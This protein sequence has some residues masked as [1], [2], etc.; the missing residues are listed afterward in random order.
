MVVGR[1]N[2][3]FKIPI[4]H[5]GGGAKNIILE[6]AIKD[7]LAL[8]EPGNTPDRPSN[9]GDAT[10][11]QLSR[12]GGAPSSST[13]THLAH[14][15]EAAF[16]LRD[17]DLEMTALTS[18]RCNLRSVTRAQFNHTFPRNL[19]EAVRK[20]EDVVKTGLGDIIEESSTPHWQNVHMVGNQCERRYW[21]TGEMQPFPPLTES[22]I[23]TKALIGHDVNCIT[24]KGPRASES[25]ARH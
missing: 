1:C 5:V 16:T 17:P 7:K 8:A 19:T 2:R 23:E 13:D 14:G 10:D 4:H 15:N 22:E 6:D 3:I 9:I 21:R 25:I 24:P 20:I 12:R 11:S 18:D